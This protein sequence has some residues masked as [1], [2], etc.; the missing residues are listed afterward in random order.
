VLAIRRN[1]QRYGSGNLA[2]GGWDLS[3]CIQKNHG[4]EILHQYLEKAFKS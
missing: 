1:I 2:P 3:N 4:I